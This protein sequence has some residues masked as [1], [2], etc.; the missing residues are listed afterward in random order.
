MIGSVQS[1]STHIR[2]IGLSQGPLITTISIMC[3]MS[4]SRQLERIDAESDAP[5]RL[6]RFETELN[7]EFEP[8]SDNPE[9][10]VPAA[11]P[12]PEVPCHDPV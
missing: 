4:D 9:V 3:D 7:R 6:H 10:V 8:M 12:T 11:T 5:R 1:N 2:P